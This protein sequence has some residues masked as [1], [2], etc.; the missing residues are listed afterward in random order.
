M[1]TKDNIV[2]D[3]CLDNEYSY[4]YYGKY[5]NGVSTISL[6]GYDDMLK[7]GVDL[8][9]YILHCFMV[10]DREHS[11]L[12]KT[13]DIYRLTIEIEEPGIIRPLFKEIS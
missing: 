2:F 11:N 5:I 10:F 4:T 13:I 12:K 7:A 1:I 3:M 6:D 9:N 8:T